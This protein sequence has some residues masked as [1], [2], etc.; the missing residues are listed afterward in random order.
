M[1]AFGQSFFVL[2]ALSW[3]VSAVADNHL[4]GGVARESFGPV[5]ETEIAAVKLQR[6]STIMEH[7]YQVTVSGLPDGEMILCR[8]Y[9]TD[10]GVRDWELQRSFG[11]ETRFFFDAKDEDLAVRCFIV[12]VE[13]SIR[14]SS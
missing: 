10:G 4:L 14:P 2:L 7:P 12:D 8:L 13:R 5:T 1:K 3:A 11:H 9:D 6:F